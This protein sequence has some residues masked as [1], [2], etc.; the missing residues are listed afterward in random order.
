MFFPVD[1]T[2]KGRIFTRSVKNLKKPNPTTSSW[3]LVQ[4]DTSVSDVPQPNPGEMSKGG[5]D[6][7]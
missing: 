2:Y 4:I 7:E 5:V 6:N 3:V 1:G